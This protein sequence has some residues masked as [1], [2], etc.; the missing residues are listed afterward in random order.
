[1]SRSLDW[2][3]EVALSSAA[4]QIGK[5]KP[6]VDAL[7]KRYLKE[8]AVRRSVDV[9]AVAMFLLDVVNQHTLSEK[10]TTH[11]TTIAGLLVEAAHQLAASSVFTKAP[12]PGYGGGKD[13]QSFIK[14]AKALLTDAKRE[15]ELKV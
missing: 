2:K 11:V 15:A 1:M 14:Q 8:L 7:R 12:G 6:K 4:R 13:R 5:L 3:A 9:S 10:M